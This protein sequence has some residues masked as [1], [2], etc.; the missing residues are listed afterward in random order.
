V[1]AYAVG[2]RAQPSGEQGTCTGGREPQ[3]LIRRSG[4]QH[5]DGDDR[6]RS[7]HQP[8]GQP[9]RDRADRPGQGDREYEAD[10]QRGRRAG[11]YRADGAGEQHAEADD[12]SGECGEPD[13]TGRQGAGA[14]QGRTGQDE[15]GLLRDPIARRTAEVDEQQCR[16]GAERRERRDVRVADRSAGD[17]E[18]RRHDDRGTTGPAQ[19]RQARVART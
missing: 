11:Q 14:H 3:R 17:R 19:R 9:V 15:P 2:L 1:P 7:A 16:E 18:D 6:R 4:P 10:Q 12:E 13:L 5:G 8:A